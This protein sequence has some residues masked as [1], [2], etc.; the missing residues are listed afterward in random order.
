MR[1]FLSLLGVLVLLGS[2]AFAQSEIVVTGKVTDQGGLPVPFATVRVK[3]T[4]IG[5]SADAEGNFTIKAL[6]TQTLVITG[7]GIVAREYPVGDGKDLAIQV[8]HQASSLSEVVVTSLGITQKSKELGYA[9]TTVSNKTLTMAKS[10]D[11]AQALNG[12]VSGLN[13]TTVNSGVFENAKINIR[14]IRSLTG[15][16]QPMLVVDGAPTP[17]GYLSSIPPDDVQ[18]VTI[19]KSAAAG[20][21]YGPEAVNGVLIITTKRGTK[22]PTITLNST[23]QAQTVSFFPKFQ[24]EFGAGAGEIIDPFGNY[25]Y[26]P[27]ENQQ[28]GPAFD[29]SIQPIGPP[30]ESLPQQMGPYN[31]AHYQDKVKFWNTGLTLQNSISVA[32]E[33]FYLSIEDAQIQG[34][35]PDD[36]NHRTS[37]RF[38]GGKTYDKF[39]VQYGLNYV[40]SNY[41]VLNESG[42]QNTFNSGAYS[43]GLFFAVMQTPSNVPLLNYKNTTSGY[44]EYSNYYNEYAASPYWI[45][46]NIRAKGTINDFLANVTANYQFLPWMKATVRLSGDLSFNQQSATNA[47]L[48]VSDWA[49]QNRYQATFFNQAG[50]VLNNSGSSS[51]LNLDYFIGGDHKINNSFSVKYTLGGSTRQNLQND[52]AVGGNNLVVPY[53]FNVASRSGD[54]NVPIYGGATATTVNGNNYTIESRLISAYGTVGFGYNDWAFIEFTGRNDWDSRL[55]Q[56]NRSF[57]YPAADLSLVLSEAIPAIKNS[58]LISYL[59]VRTAASKSGNVNIGPYALNATYSQPAGFPYGTTAGY[60][61]NTTIPNPNLKPEFVNTIEAGLEIGFMQNR[62]NFEGSYYYQKNTDQVLNVSQSWATGYP[63]GLANAADFTNYGV[64]MSLNLTPLVNVGK[65]RI[66][67]KMV[68]SYNNNFVT[69]TLGNIPVVIGGTTGFIQTFSGAPTASNIATVGQPAFQFQLTDYLRDTIPGDPNF[70]KVVIDPVT[71]NPTNASDPIVRGRALPLWVVGITPSYT[72]GNFSVNMTFEYKGG[73]NFYSGLGPDMDFAGISARSAEYGRKRFV[74]PNSVYFDAGGKSQANTNIMVTDGNYGFWT[75]TPQN[76]SIATNYFASADAWRMRELNISYNIPTKWL[77]NGNV[78]KRLIISFVAKNL[79][80]WTP[81]SNQ[82]G[83]P[84]FNYN[85]TGNTFGLAS[86]FQSPASRV[87]GGSLTIGF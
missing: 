21:L 18:D 46:A 83:D 9:T 11:I 47:P 6:S 32:G 30:L 79:F 71:G 62:I 68:A 25:G 1:K 61:D 81:S 63:N 73:Y 60:T 85:A 59:K 48:Q 36:K 15:N 53:L 44:G 50:S 13:I 39:S 20:A 65:G 74:F 28:F 69:K 84:E 4:K 51:R 78:V 24:K 87:F 5:T 45:I 2:I 35:V 75:S 29:N 43:G 72:I 82:W 66:E 7:T 55:S 16:N 38:N 22:R 27:Y 58:A 8:Q 42:I 80:I 67:L 14:G 70:G 34:L 86:S 19:L 10:V 49:T 76:T 41:N 64:D 12:K 26:V 77:S 40:Q 52:V 33:D 23:V 54:A 37:F 56:A 3:G 17:L 57:F 31:N